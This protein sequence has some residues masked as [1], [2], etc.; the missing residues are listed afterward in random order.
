M[1]E[2]LRIKIGLIH[3]CLSWEAYQVGVDNMYSRQ[4]GSRGRERAIRRRVSSES[5]VAVCFLL[6]E[7]DFDWKIRHS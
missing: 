3:A 6:D 5:L 7:K 4:V 1:A 2:I